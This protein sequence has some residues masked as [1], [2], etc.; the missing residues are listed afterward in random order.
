MTFSNLYFTVIIMINIVFTDIM[1][2]VSLFSPPLQS[3]SVSPSSSSATMIAVWP[4]F[5]AI[6]NGVYPFLSAMSILL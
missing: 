4:F 6:C 5:A 2:G 1:R 3:M